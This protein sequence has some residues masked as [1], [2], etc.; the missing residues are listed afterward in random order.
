MACAPSGVGH[1]SNH[2]TNSGSELPT[3]PDEIKKMLDQ[4]TNQD[5]LMKLIQHFQDHG[6]KVPDEYA[7]M[8]PNEGDING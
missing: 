4:I 6:I 2:H 8:V 1:S 3:D 5:E 7:N